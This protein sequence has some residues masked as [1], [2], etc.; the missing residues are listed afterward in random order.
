MDNEQIEEKSISLL[1]KLPK[2][3][4]SNVLDYVGRKKFPPLIIKV[5]NKMEIVIS[6]DYFNYKIT[7]NIRLS[8]IFRRNVIYYERPGPNFYFKLKHRDILINFLIKTILYDLNYYDPFNV[9]IRTY[10]VFNFDKNVDKLKISNTLR[11]IYRDEDHNYIMLSKFINMY[12]D[13][14]GIIMIDD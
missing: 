5:D 13:I 4:M 6:R 10:I 3:L 1:A 12:L 2:E 14:L 9:L 7:K 11:N 8:D